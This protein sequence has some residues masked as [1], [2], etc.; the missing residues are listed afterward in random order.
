MPICSGEMIYPVRTVLALGT[1][2]AGILPQS[3]SN[4]IFS[5]TVAYKNRASKLTRFSKL[6]NKLRL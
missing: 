4:I 2:Q 6:Q 5:S 1:R 3:A